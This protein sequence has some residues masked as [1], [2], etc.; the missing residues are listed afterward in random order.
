VNGLPWAFLPK[1]LLRG[2]LL[3]DFSGWVRLKDFSFGARE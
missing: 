3:K 2:L 1:D